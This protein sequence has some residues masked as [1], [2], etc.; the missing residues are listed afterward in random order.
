MKNGVQLPMIGMFSRYKKHS[1]SLPFLHKPRHLA[2]ARASDSS[3]PR[4]CSAL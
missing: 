3:H 4:L 2:T 1:T